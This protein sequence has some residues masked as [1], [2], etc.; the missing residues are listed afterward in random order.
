MLFGILL[1]V[2]VLIVYGSLYPWDF[3]AR[4]LD[5]NPLSILLHSW[6]SDVIDR[7]FIADVIINIAIYV[8]LGM[9]GYLAF[10]RYRLW[11]LEIAGP[12]LL[13]ALLSATM[14]ML[15]LFTPHRMCSA[16]DLAN[17][18]LGS[19]LGV[20][21][22]IVFAHVVNPPLVPWH[23]SESRDR[24]AVAL[25]FCGFIALTF[26]FFPVMWLSMWRL[27]VETFAHG[28]VVSP[29]PLLLNAAEWFAAGRLLVAAGAR[30]PRRWLAFA[31]LLIPLQMA[32][33]NRFP[34]PADLVGA[35]AAVALFRWLGEKREAD[36]GGAIFL[37]LAL[38][39]TGLAP[40]HFTEQSQGFSPI[41]FAGVM[42]TEWQSGLQI[43]I[44]KLF[45]YG[46]AIWLMRRAGMRLLRS[47]L[48]ATAVLAAIEAAQT[49]IPGHVA[50]TTDPLLALLIG[51]T[52]RT[53]PSVGSDATILR[54]T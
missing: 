27:K 33:V 18:T 51:I 16:I 21:A 14:E 23:S 11:M 31:L 41:P 13:G 19:A 42:G 20:I 5:T 1:I 25:L 36:R 38:V 48:V 6:N 37:L 49:Y 10:R 47:T 32:I 43:L 45:E 15:Q 17:N 50:E 9:T 29:V 28:F 24:S 46:A 22:G 44:M 34:M 52:L 8:P 26:P 54:R 12:V 30:S 2:V 4:Q 7:R 39:L 3:V 35:T 53:L 40:F